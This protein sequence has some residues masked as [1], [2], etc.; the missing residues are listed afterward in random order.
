MTNIDKCCTT[1]GKHFIIMLFGGVYLLS[2]SIASSS[3]SSLRGYWM[4][5]TIVTASESVSGVPN[6]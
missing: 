4:N 6:E 1:I 2:P 3:S 5:E